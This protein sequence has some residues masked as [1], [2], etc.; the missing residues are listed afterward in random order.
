MDAIVTT[1]ILD[2]VLS[3]SKELSSFVPIAS[4]PYPSPED[5][6]LDSGLCRLRLTRHRTFLHAGRENA[7]LV[8]CH[9]QDSLPKG[10]TLLS[11]FQIQLEST[12]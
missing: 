3:V 7:L 5:V 9:I 8:A 2:A 11:L 10:H 4:V 12:T 6:P 1:E